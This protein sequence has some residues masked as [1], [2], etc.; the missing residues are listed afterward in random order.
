MTDWDSV[1]FVGCLTLEGVSLACALLVVVTW[2]RR[3][4]RATPVSRLRPALSAV[5]AGLFLLMSLQGEVAFL[6]LLPVI[7]FAWV[8]VRRTP[9]G[10]GPQG[11]A[12][13]LA[14]FAAVAWTAAAITQYAAA[15]SSKTSTG[16][17][18]ADLLLTVPMLAFC[19][20]VA[21]SAISRARSRPQPKPALQ[22]PPPLP[23][24]SKRGPGAPPRDHQDRS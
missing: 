3:D 17:I 7:L 14:F 23:A 6:G 20:W 5:G 11:D 21:V 22:T 9:E 8:V 10:Q 18:R 24:P 15:Q 12:R 16:I 2:M 13:L 1:A 4:H 19:T